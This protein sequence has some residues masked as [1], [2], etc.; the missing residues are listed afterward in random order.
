MD[1]Q[2]GQIIAVF[3]LA[4]VMALVCNLYLFFTKTE[5]AAYDVRRLVA[6]IIFS[7]ILGFL[8]FYQFLQGLVTIEQINWAYMIGMI[9]MYQGFLIYINKGVDWLWFKLFGVPVMVKFKRNPDG[10]VMLPR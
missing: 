4:I 2:L 5:P 9:A 3:V 10:T 7:L 1:F 8:G 6:T